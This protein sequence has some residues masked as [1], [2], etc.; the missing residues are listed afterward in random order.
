MTELRTSMAAVLLFAVTVAVTSGVTFDV[1]QYGAK[2]DNST[3]DTTAVRAA[4]AAA[5]AAGG[6]S[7][8]FPAGHCFLT[9][10]FNISSHVEVIIEAGATIFGHAKADWPIVDPRLVWPQC[11]CAITTQ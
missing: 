4:F 1:T 9:G 6:G 2:G 10:P 11:E 8:R 7:V 3:D 5:K